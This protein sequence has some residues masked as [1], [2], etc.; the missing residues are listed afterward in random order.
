MAKRPKRDM[1]TDQQI[2][3][4]LQ[5][6]YGLRYIAA[7]NLG[8]A[9]STITRRVDNS[10]ELQ[11]LLHESAEAGLDVA[12]SAL[13][14]A[15][16]AGKSWAVC[17]YLKCKGKARGYME[18]QEIAAVVNEPPY[19]SA[20]RGMTDEQLDRIIAR[21]EARETENQEKPTP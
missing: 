17:F 4:A 11:T 10:P 9:C 7:Q 12:E 20:V 5:R 2:G 1:P 6:S 21:A 15:V 18:R 13:M 3:V 8:V 16:K 14:Q 19:L